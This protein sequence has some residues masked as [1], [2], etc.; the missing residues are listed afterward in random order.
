MFYVEDMRDYVL[1]KLRNIT[2]T[3][4]LKRRRAVK[5]KL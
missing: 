4:K 3:Y 2:V 1:I 5:V